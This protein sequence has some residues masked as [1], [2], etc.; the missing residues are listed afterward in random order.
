MTGRRII[1][2]NPTK[3]LTTQTSRLQALRDHV[4]GIVDDL[5][6]LLAKTPEERLQDADTRESVMQAF[7]DLSEK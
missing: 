1:F 5:D 4:Q 3:L 6:T 7:R 2:S